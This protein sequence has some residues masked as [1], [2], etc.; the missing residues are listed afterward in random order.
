[1]L[2]RQL[3]DY[4]TYTFTYLLAD[5][6]SKEAVLI[7]SVKEQVERDIAL[8]KDLGLTLKYTLETHVHADHVT[9]GGLLRQR[10]GSQTILNEKANSSC[11]DLNL[12]HGAKIKFGKYELEVRSTPGHT[13]GCSTF[14]FLGDADH[15][16]M[17]FTGDALF[18]RGCG[19]TDF[20]Q[21]SPEKLYHSIHEQIYTLPDYT[22]VYPGHDYKGHMLSTVG[23]EKQ[24]NPRINVAVT[25]DDFC[26]TMKGLNLPNPKKI[27]EAV[28][29]NLNCGLDKN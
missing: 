8:I 29:A 22:I 19:R 24:F 18:V 28:P 1:M 26:K 6:E 20:Q 13:D 11:S 7:D 3:F 23:E 16:P 2:F 14:V 12:Q 5:E 4:E 10:L 27:H 25:E 17:A 9:G 21:G 15:K